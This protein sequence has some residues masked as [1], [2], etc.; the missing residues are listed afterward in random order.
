MASGETFY[1][2]RKRKQSFLKKRTKKLLFLALA[3]ATTGCAPAMC[4]AGLTRMT[5]VDLFF[6]RNIER[7][8][9]V[10]QGQWADF[11]ARTL[12]P[13]FPDGFTV[14]DTHGQW[15]DHRTGT[16]ERENSWVV[17]A[18]LP[19][20]TDIV[21]RASAVTAAYRVLFSQQSV[22]VIVEPVCASF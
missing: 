6:G 3:S 21:P 2:R 5:A 14:F 8:R 16:I 17:R 4:P 10:S 7:R 11:L 13:S 12:T 15:M 19:A 22:G 9:E 1:E 20:Y 18:V